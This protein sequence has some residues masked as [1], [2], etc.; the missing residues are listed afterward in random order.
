M[1]AHFEWRSVPRLLVAVCGGWA[2]SLA[3]AAIGQRWLVMPRE[4]LIV[5]II[6]WITPIMFFIVHRLPD[7]GPTHDGWMRRDL[8]TVLITGASLVGTWLAVLLLLQTAGITPQ[9]EPGMPVFTAMAVCGFTYVATWGIAYVAC[10]RLDL[11]APK[12][13][14]RKRVRRRK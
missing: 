14:P 9:G 6:L 8:L 13:E 1:T 12:T 3:C 11:L 7:T 10:A 4:L 5:A 2:A